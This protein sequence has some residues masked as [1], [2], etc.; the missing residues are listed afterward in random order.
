LAEDGAVALV[1]RVR[2]G[3]QIEVFRS[4]HGGELVGGAPWPGVE[5]AHHVP[6]RNVR[7][8]TLELSE[9]AFEDVRDPQVVGTAQI[10]T[11]SRRM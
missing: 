7:V 4:D 3:R 5:E 11:A 10:G 6:P 2:G 9:M 8:F 1:D